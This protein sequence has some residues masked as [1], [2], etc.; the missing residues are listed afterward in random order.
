MSR[1]TWIFFGNLFFRVGQWVCLVWLM[2]SQVKLVSSDPGIRS[3][4]FKYGFYLVELADILFD[5]FCHIFT[6]FCWSFILVRWMV[7][8]SFCRVLYS[9]AD[10]AIESDFCLVWHQ[11]SSI[12]NPE[13][14][15]QTQLLILAHSARAV[16]YTDCISEEGKTSPQRVSW[17]WH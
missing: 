12:Q 16:E 9:S 15:K 11:A 7:F 2:C 17:I 5:Y 13:R 1:S 6:V 10:L 4:F 8:G 14:I 3:S